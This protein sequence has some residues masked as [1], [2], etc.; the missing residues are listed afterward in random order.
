MGS[1][2][3]MDILPSPQPLLLQ[4]LG[5]PDD[6]AGGWSHCGRAVISCNS[7]S[8]LQPQQLPGHPGVLPLLREL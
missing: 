5:F 2:F 4:G 7:T 6:K 3:P 1:V 8:F